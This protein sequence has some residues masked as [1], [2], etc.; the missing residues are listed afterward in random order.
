[1]LTALGLVAGVTGAALLI[2][3]PAQ[4]DEPTVTSVKAEITRRIDLRLAALKRDDAALVAAKH[5]T[6]AHRSTLRGLVSQDTTG[7]TGLK[8]KVAGETTLTALRADAQSM[9][10]DYRIFILVGPKVRL[11]IAGDAETDAIARAQTAHDKLVGLVA[12]AKTNGKDTTAAEQDLAAMQAAIT[13][14][15]SDLSGQVA[16][17]L[18]IQPGPDGAAI[19]AA[20]AAVRKAVGATRADIKTAVADAKKVTAFLR[21]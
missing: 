13:K 1:M 19:R 14:A 11:T 10:N 3:A 17:L 5:I 20:V 9:V 15:S 16:A 18:A 21:G 12:K 4:A 7:L 6:D 8:T 2:A